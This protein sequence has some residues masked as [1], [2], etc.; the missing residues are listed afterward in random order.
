MAAS[1]LTAVEGYEF[2]GGFPTP[3]TVQRA[4]DD[5][6]LVRAITAYRFFFASVSA[7]S[8]YKGNARRDAGLHLPYGPAAVAAGF[9]AAGT[10]PSRR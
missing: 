8:V 3:E 1:M 9:P 7:Q 10:P 2:E 5:A 6:D 4:Y